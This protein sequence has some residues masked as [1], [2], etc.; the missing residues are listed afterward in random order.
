MGHFGL[1]QIF[2][3]CLFCFALYFCLQ[4]SFMLQDVRQWCVHSFYCKRLFVVFQNYPDIDI[5]IILSKAIE[6]KRPRVVA[7]NPP[8]THQR[9]KAGFQ[10][11]KRWPQFHD[12]MSF[13]SSKWTRILLLYNVSL[14]G[15]VPDFSIF[16][17]IT[18]LDLVISGSLPSVPNS[19]HKNYRKYI[20]ISGENK[21]VETLFSY[22]IYYIVHPKSWEGFLREDF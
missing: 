16:L 9:Q 14:A 15:P 17:F 6:L 7:P 1:G 21:E 3:T 10:F 20:N 18:N 5:H 22:R 19:P 8:H 13:F 4:N 11:K 12:N 2:S